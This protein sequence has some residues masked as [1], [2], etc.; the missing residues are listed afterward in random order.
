M[1][2]LT[3]KIPTLFIIFIIFILALSL[4]IMASIASYFVSFFP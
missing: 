3:L 4:F 2:S 1:A